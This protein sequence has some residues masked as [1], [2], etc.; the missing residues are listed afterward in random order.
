MTR[1][2]FLLGVG[3]QRAGT[4]WLHTQLQSS[5]V[6]ARFP[7]K[8]F[9]IWD[10]ISSPLFSEFDLRA[11]YFSLNT[12]KSLLR[13]IRRS[14]L[15]SR[16]E[17]RRKM[18]TS[19]ENYFDFFRDL[20]EAQGCTIASDITPSYC[21]LSEQVFSDIREG[22]E[23]YDIDVKVVYI[24]RDPADRCLSAVRKYR[25]DNTTKQGV[26]VILPEEEAF[27]RYLQS[28][29]AKVRTDYPGT[30]TR[31]EKVFPAEK[32]HIGFFETM[33]QERELVRLEQFL[34]IDIDRAAVKVRRNSTEASARDDALLREQAEQQF[35]YVYEYCFQR[36]PH[37]TDLWRVR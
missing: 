33:F 5:G 28:D 12:L 32:M 1:R 37:L 22:F 8:E 34:G 25:R 13:R 17:L 35:R 3:A 14:D 15:D 16:T 26:D 36:F 24:L 9:H 19:P 31:L 27:L 20:L 23:A 29:H 18:Q 11:G 6:V 7:V 4:T 30:L 2:V 10:A 21:A